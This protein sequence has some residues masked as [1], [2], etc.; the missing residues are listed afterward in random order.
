MNPAIF[1]AYDTRGVYPEEIDEEIVKNI[2]I[3]YVNKYKLLKVAV[4]RDGRISSPV[5]ANAFIEGIVSAGADCVDLGIV[6][7]DLVYFASAAYDFDGAVMITASHNPKQYNGI[8]M[9]L[10]DAVPLSGDNGLFAIRDLILNDQ[11]VISKIVGEKS[12]YDPI[13]DYVKKL[14]SLIDLTQIKSK[15]IVIDAG[16]GVG[17]K[18]SEKVFA[19]LPVEIVPLYFDIDGNFPNHQPSPIEEKNILDLK[20]KVV[21]AKAD[22]GLAFDGDGDRVYMIDEKGAT[23]SASVTSAMIAKRILQK[24]PGALILYNAICGWIVPETIARYGGKS[25]ITPVGH[26]LIKPILRRENGQFA[27]EHSGHYYFKELSYAD[28]GMLAALFVLELV[29]MDNRPISE[30]TAEFNKY[31]LSGEINSKVKNAK[32]KIA[33]LRKTF[34]DG[35][36]SELDGLSVE[37]TDW[38]FNVRS[39]NTEP[40]LRLNVEAK[41]EQLMNEKRDLLLGIIQQL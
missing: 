34:S 8:K 10:K 9:V 13:P 22:F 33:D 14:H 35:I 20:K 12:T 40:L 31:F 1:K 41:S 37:Y 18:L 2:A 36:I 15:K 23:I 26:S 16:N 5:L 25:Q 29:S 4:G 3:A 7:T 30:I 19:D 11:L 38:R 39:S 21:E 17:G 24:H 27:C 32:E 28:S 6:T